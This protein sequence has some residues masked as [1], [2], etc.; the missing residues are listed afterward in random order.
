MSNNAY[1]T[2]EV[3]DNLGIV[4]STLRKWCLLLEEG[5]YTFDRNDKDQRIFYEHDVMTLRAVK[6]LTQKDHMTLANATKKAIQ[7]AKSREFVTP[8]DT[9]EKGV[10]ERDI[11]SD[12][13]RDGTINKLLAHIEQQERFNR[14]LLDRLDRQQQYIEERDKRDR[15][16]IESRE[17]R[18]E[19]R[20]RRLMEIH[21]ETR[22]MRDMI[23]AAKEETDKNASKGLLARLFG[24]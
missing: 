1:W 24:K 5:G 7:Q 16:L 9:E 10:A 23:A 12:I 20:D 19:E 4:S 15:M 11:N 22:E 17:K 3:A 8:T 21:R 2:K 14:E 18:V 6:K 13:E